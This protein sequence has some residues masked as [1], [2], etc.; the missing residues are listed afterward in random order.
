MVRELSVSKHKIR[1][2]TRTVDVKARCHLRALSRERWA[3]PWS[4]FSFPVKG[5]RKPRPTAQHASRPRAGCPMRYSSSYLTPSM[6]H[7]AVTNY[8]PPVRPPHGGGSRGLNASPKRFQLSRREPLLKVSGLGNR[9]GFLWQI[10]GSEWVIS[11]L[12]ILAY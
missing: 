8:I 2:N 11:P 3:T 10:C 4:G 7:T 1:L 12:A 5:V 6:K 9:G